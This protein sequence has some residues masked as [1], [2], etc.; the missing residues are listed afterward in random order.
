MKA[1]LK[2][3]Q[4]VFAPSEVESLDISKLESDQI[5]RVKLNGSPAWI[6]SSGFDAIE[7]LMA[8]KPSAAEGTRLRFKKHAWAFHNLVGHPVMQMLAWAGFKKAAI[9]FHDWSAPSMR[10]FSG[11]SPPQISDAELVKQID[12]LNS[13]LN[14]SRFDIVDHAYETARIEEMPIESI[15]AYL[16]VPFT[17]RHRLEN[18]T[19]FRDRAK[20]ELLRRGRD[21]DR[22]LRGLT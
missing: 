17:A 19:A 16:R 2:A 3:G 15:I 1:F 20:A 7:I 9:R 8:I 11:I 5:V 22:L 12:E 18:W 21:P 6:V 4:F 14:A 10:A 13:A